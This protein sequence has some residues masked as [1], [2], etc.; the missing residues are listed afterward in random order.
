MADLTNH[1]ED[2]LL[3]WMMTTGAVTRPTAWHVA[4]HMSDP[5]ETGA[6]GEVTTSEDADYV[7]D[8]VTFDDAASGQAPSDAAVTWTV[9]SASAGYTVSHI[10]VW[11]ASTAGNCLLKGALPVPVALSANQVFTLGIGAIIAALD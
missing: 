11:D 10:S 9:N 1:A 4:L 8:S 3:N 5:G 7:R 6:A 2:L